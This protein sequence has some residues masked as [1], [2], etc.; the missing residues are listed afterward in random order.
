M[1]ENKLVPPE[2]K[3]AEGEMREGSQSRKRSWGWQMQGE[4]CQKLRG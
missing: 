4:M 3:E 1:Q 2:A